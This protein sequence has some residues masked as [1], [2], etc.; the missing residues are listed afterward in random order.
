MLLSNLEANSNAIK[1]YWKEEIEHQN[2]IL[3]QM[4]STLEE[5]NVQRSNTIGSSSSRRLSK[6]IL[7]SF[8]G[9]KRKTSILDR[10]LINSRKYINN[11]L[12]N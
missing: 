3:L 2:L 7:S 1:N 10:S 11:F 9:V 5:E 8:D 4:K 6:K 12:S